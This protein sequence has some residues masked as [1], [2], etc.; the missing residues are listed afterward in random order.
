MSHPFSTCGLYKSAFDTPN[1]APATKEAL[2]AVR[3]I[4]NRRRWGENAALM[5]AIK[6]NVPPLMYW[7]AWDFENRR[8]Q[9]AKN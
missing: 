3:A 6:M 2:A 5:F 1:P 9:N 7:T 4:K 8:S